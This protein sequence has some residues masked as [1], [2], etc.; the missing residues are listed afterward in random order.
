MSR[1][2]AFGKGFL[3]ALSAL[4]KS[5][6]NRGSPA[7]GWEMGLTP[8]SLPLPKQPHGNGARQEG[9]LRHKCKVLPVTHLVPQGFPLES[10]QRL[11][12]EPCPPYRH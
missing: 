3:A 7:L 1:E 9:T 4:L 8:N 10:W 11:S 2:P 12:R 5:A 6:E